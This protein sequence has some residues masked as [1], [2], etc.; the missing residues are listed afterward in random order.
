MEAFSDIGRAFSNTATTLTKALLTL[1]TATATF[2]VAY[3]L[4]SLRRGVYWNASVRDAVANFAPTIGVVAG[5]CIARWARLAHGNGVAALPALSMPAVFGT[6][7]GR[8]WLVPLLNLPVWA[9][10]AALLP[11]IMATVLLFLDQNITVRLVNNPQWCMTKGRRRNNK[12]DGMHLDLLVISLLTAIQSILG[13]PWLVAATVRSVSHVRALSVYNAEGQIVGNKEQRVTGVSIHALIG[14][15]VLFAR[16]RALLAQIPLSVLT[17]FFLFLGATS[18][19]GNE[20]WERILG[21]FKD[22]KLA[23]K[24]R[25]TD[26]VPTSITNI[27]TL[28]QVVCLGIMFWV[29]ESSIGVLFPVV[30][31][32]LAPLRF[33]LERTGIVKKEYMDILDED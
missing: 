28:I 32:L 18:L 20:M 24:E 3:S 26:T 4:R 30:I 10:W 16:P 33:A 27:F 22:R 31:A 6:T 9:R 12:V 2:T 25:W 13:M 19:P 29:K 8:P 17:G 5:A 7:T 1:V 15:C 23:A 11:A 21:V 14:C